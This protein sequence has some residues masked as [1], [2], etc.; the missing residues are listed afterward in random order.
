M[1]TRHA[2]R[3]VFAALWIALSFIT[4]Q[5][6]WASSQD[7]RPTPPPSTLAAPKNAPGY[8]PSSGGSTSYERIQSVTLSREPSGSWKLVVEVYIA[9]PTGCTPGKPCPEYDNS[10]EYVNAWIDWNGD[11]TWDAS[12]RVLDAALTGYLAINYFGTMTAVAIFPQP[13]SVTSEP[14]WLRANLGWGHDPNDPCEASWTWGNVVDQ[15]YI[16]KTPEIKSITVQG[17]KWSLP[18]WPFSC[19]LG[20]PGN[21]PQTGSKVRLE[22]NIDTPAGYEVV[23]CSWSGDLT[24]GEGRANHNCLYEYTPATGPGPSVETYGEKNVTLTV[25]YRHKA[26]GATGQV[27]K[28]HE[29]NVF[30]AK[31]GDDD[32]D[33]IPNWFEY[34]GDDGAVPGLDAPDT[35]YNPK[36]RGYGAFNPRSDNIEL[37]DLA[38]EYDPP[39]NIPSGPTCPGAEDLGNTE[40]IDTA[41]VTLAH[42]RRHKT[43]HHNWDSIWHGLPD[44]DKGIP[45]GAYHD[46]LPDSYENT[47]GTDP[48]NVDSC[49]LGTIIDKDYKYYGDNEFDARLAEKG[50]RGNK[51]KDWANP[52]KQAAIAS[53]ISLSPQLQQDMSS[54]KSG[55]TT[56][57]VTYSGLTISATS[58]FGTFTGSYS[59][60]GVDTDGD[61]FYNS[62]KLA[63]GV[64][65][66]EQALY[67]VVA[68]L[69][70]GSGVQIAWASTQ[71]RLNIGTHTVDLLFDGISIR[72]SRL[73]GP[74][75]VARVELLMGREEILVAAADNVHTTAAYQYTDF[76]P[77]VVGFTRSFSD[78]GVDTD[79]D[80]LYNS[81]RINI[82]L[83][84]QKAGT[85]MIT[86]ELEN[87]DSIAVASTTVSL[88]TGN[89]N[90]ALD[91]DGQLVFQQR[92]NGPY[93]LRKLRVEDEAGNEIDFIYDAYTT[94]A[95]SYT[96]FQRGGATINAASYSDQGLDLDGDGDFDYLRVQFQL[97][98]HQAGGYRLLA[99]LDDN[100]GEF[101]TSVERTFDLTAGSTLTVTL[102]FPGSAIYQHGVNGPYQVVRV[103]LLNADGDIV[104]YQHLGHTTQAYS[105]TQFGQPSIVATGPY[106]DYG[107]DTDGN[108]LYNQLV[109]E[110][111][112]F[113][114][115]DGVVVAIGRLVDSTGQ[116]IGRA[117]NNVQVTAGT[118]QI[119]ALSF[120]GAPI[121]ANRRNGPYQLRDLYVYNT[122]DPGQGAYVALAHTTAVYRYAQFDGPGA[123][124]ITG[125]AEAFDNAGQ[126]IATV[127]LDSPVPAVVPKPKGG[128]R[129]DCQSQSPIQFCRTLPK[130]VKLNQAFTIKLTLKNI[131]SSTLARVRMEDILPSNVQLVS[132]KLVKECR[133]LRKR[134]TCSNTYR[135]KVI[136]ASATAD[137]MVV[138]QVLGVEGLSARDGTIRFLAQGEGIKDIQIAVFDLSGRLIFNSDWVANNFL[139]N[140]QNMRGKPLA[141]GVYLYVV[142]V[143]GFDGREYVSEVRKLVILR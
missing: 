97:N 13:A 89:Q 69:E 17:C 49:S 76:D 1:L 99:D 105:Y 31:K 45:S 140:G 68:W 22:A 127:V 86:G 74:Y 57:N 33:R 38:A 62:L 75:N 101:I 41:A 110:V 56:P 47:L 4:S 137:Q 42:E 134:A 46:D 115:N 81:L 114:S 79:S 67:N 91:F 29:Y 61:G 132:G 39:L 118:S 36:R 82:G 7:P 5:L 40:G 53:S 104:D 93:H 83:D 73:N 106:R 123:T 133:N 37:G 138:L 16:F 112:F 70:N 129:T 71:I 92:E 25:T 96:Q 117:T 103:T 109:I 11:K 108:S 52:G 43:I 3:A 35:S 142:R 128:T 34:W 78:A 100:N 119:I 95:Y 88:S 77:P 130:Q 12:E 116:E 10:P 6:A 19:I 51:N 58:A 28:D 139:W 59:D 131:G 120:D 2:A 30:F 124:D 50:V 8:C 18:F 24:P 143:R 107:Q 72:S 26:S 20:T 135:V 98:V 121:R 122:G 102:D 87:S 63:V 65:I 54:T 80:G 90:V 48:N 136:S 14:T 111:G 125:T 113:S 23:K 84:V 9:N 60:T 85:Y 126:P 21:N 55:P 32:G 44:S 64:Q 27:S 66:N 141:N 15:Q 94:A